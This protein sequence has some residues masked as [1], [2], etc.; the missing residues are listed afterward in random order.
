M[1]FFDEDDEPTSTTQRT[2]AQPKPRPRSGRPAGGRS[3]DAQNVLVRRMV[4]V[5]V[6]GLV[7]LLLFVIVSGCNDRR[8]KNALKDYNLQVSNIGTQSAPYSS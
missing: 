2:R 5:V 4:A 3:S 6:A 1:S 7:L 8:N